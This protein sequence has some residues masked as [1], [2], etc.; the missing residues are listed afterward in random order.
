MHPQNVSV[1]GCALNVGV[2]VAC[3]LLVLGRR[4]DA[5]PGRSTTAMSDTTIPILDL[6]PYLDGERSTLDATAAKLQ[7]INETIGF[8]FIVNRGVKRSLLDATFAQTARFH[9]QKPERKMAARINPAMQG[10]IGMRAMATGDY[11]AWFRGRNYDH[12]RKA[13]AEAAV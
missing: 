9:A 11:L 6:G 1:G 12:V 10:Y 13:N 3:A 8:L 2:F 5:T 7:H 4:R